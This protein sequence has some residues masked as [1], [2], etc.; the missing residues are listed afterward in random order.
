MQMQ[1]FT[2]S[3]LSEGL[4]K[5]F[6]EYHKDS[7]ECF[8]YA[9]ALLVFTQNNVITQTNQ[10]AKQNNHK[11]KKTTYPWKSHKYKF[12]PKFYHHCQKRPVRHDWTACTW[13]LHRFHYLAPLFP[14]YK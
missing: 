11:N 12:V 7:K 6:R 3:W 14:I 9:L 2:W 1:S 5:S 4:Y 8:Y 13:K 10:K